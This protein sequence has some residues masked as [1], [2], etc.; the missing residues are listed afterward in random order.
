MFAGRASGSATN[1]PQPVA[2]LASRFDFVMYR[3]SPDQTR[4]AYLTSLDAG[5]GIP[6]DDPGLRQTNQVLAVRR[7]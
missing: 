4:V 3:L 2:A 1:P 6:I 7:I 5:G